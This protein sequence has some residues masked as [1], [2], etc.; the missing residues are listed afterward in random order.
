M[1]AD[2]QYGPEGLRLTKISEGF[3]SKAYPDPATHAEPWTIAYG[4]TSG[5]QEGDTCTLE[6]GEAWLIEDV[7][8]A[9]DLLKQYVTRDLA[10][11]EADAC[12]D[13]LYNVGPG[14]PGER[15][16]LIWLRSGGHSTLLRK[17]NA[18]DP[19]AADEFPK[20]AYPPLPGLVI[21]CA[22]RKQLFEMGTWS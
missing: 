6:Q 15:D 1:N 19:T 2:L 7:Q 4:H 14:A 18:N 17:I 3:E 21:R 13:M 12:I 10:Q 11:G 9:L 16:G 8:T 22:R 5:V 20:W